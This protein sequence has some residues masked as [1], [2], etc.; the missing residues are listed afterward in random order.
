M[1][2]IC[3]PRAPHVTQETPSKPLTETPLFLKDS[4]LF[5][6]Y[7]YNISHHFIN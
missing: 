6:T 5:E 7:Q 3:G 1:R 2:L 4:W